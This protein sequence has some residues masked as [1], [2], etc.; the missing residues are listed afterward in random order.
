[1]AESRQ[2][3]PER[4]FEGAPPVSALP[5]TR[6]KVVRVWYEDDSF[7]VVNPNR[8]RLLFNFEAEH[9]KEAPE[10]VAENM[11][12]IWHALARPEGSLE[13]WVETVAEIEWLEVERGKAL[14]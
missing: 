4:A 8:P 2:P 3:K 7:V 9:H 5:V 13:A 12:L 1:M 11:W 6:R 14:S 10:T